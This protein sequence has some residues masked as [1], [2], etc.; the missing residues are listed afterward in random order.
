MRIAVGS[1]HAGLPLKDVLAKHLAELGHEV[2]DLGTHD[3]EPVDYPDYG[4]AVGRAVAAGAVELGVCCC[5]TGIGIA[6]AA[7]K[8]PGVR[9]AVCHD[10]SSARLAREHNDANV[11]C[12]G[13]R[14]LGPV[15]ALDAVDA[16]LATGFAGGRHVA[17]VEKLR[18]L[19][20]GR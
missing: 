12:F 1:D 14:L 11:V 9:A 15:V 20:A 8:V 3:L 4:A 17:R 19:E 7:N 6:I 5:G 13:A 2:S 16:F 10:V 18:A